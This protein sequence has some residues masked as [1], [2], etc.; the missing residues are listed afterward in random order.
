M[1][2]YFASGMASAMETNCPSAQCSEPPMLSAMFFGI[3]S[4]WP[5]AADAA[6]TT[7]ASAIAVD[8]RISV[9]PVSRRFIT[10]RAMFICRASQIQTGAEAP[11]ELPQQELFLNLL[12]EVIPDSHITD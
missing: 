12:G 11:A 9:P 1:N 8:A 2:P 3:S 6:R 4:F 7:I 5:Q 10:K